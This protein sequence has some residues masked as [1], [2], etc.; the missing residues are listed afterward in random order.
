MW[1]FRI[2]EPSLKQIELESFSLDHTKIVAPYVRLSKRVA[3]PKSEYEIST[4]DFRIRTPNT[5]PLSPKIT[6]SL[7]HLFAVACRSEAEENYPDLKIL[8]VSPMGCRTGYYI[9][10]L[11]KS[12]TL[13][14]DRATSLIKNMLLSALQLDELP[15]ARIETCG[16]YLE[17]NFA[18]AIYEILSL[19]KQEI[20]PLEHPPQLGHL[21]RL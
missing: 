19:T 11:N 7:E 4:F 13:S 10:I 12:K 15:G 9:T 16:A 20:I 17:H 14:L 6:H 2:G 8:D 21:S 18:G 1:L 3:V 5:E